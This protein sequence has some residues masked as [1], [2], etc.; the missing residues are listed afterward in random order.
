MDKQKGLVEVSAERAWKFLSSVKLA[1]VLLIILAIVSIVGTVIEQNQPTEKYLMEYSRG[2]VAVLD[3]FGFFDMYQTWWFVVLLFL[4]T[5]NLTV[6]TLDRFPK[7]WTIIRAPLRPIEDTALKAVPF[8]KEIAIQGGIDEAKKRSAEVLHSRKYRYL[9]LSTAEMTQFYMQ[10]G[11]YSRLGVYI[12]HVS[13][14]LIFMGALI[15]GVFGFKGFLRLDEGTQSNVVS[16]RNA[17][18]WDAIMSA[19]GVRESRVTINPA[20]GEKTLPLGFYLRCLDFEVDYY[21]DPR[22]SRP[23]GMAQEYY[24]ILRVLDESGRRTLIDQLRIEVNDPLTYRGITFYQS[25]YG[26]VSGTRGVIL[27]NVMQKTGRSRKETILIEP[28]SETYVPSIDRRIKVV[29]VALFGERD[30][31]TGQ[32]IYYRPRNNEFINPTVELEV[33]KGR[34]GKIPLYRTQVM[35]V[36]IMAPYM[37]E[38]YTIEYHDYWGVRYTGLQVTKDPGVWVVYVGF[39]LLCF[40]PLIAFFGS[41]RKLWVRITDNKGRALVTVAGSSNRNRLGFERE[42]NRI[43]DEI[44]R[45]DERRK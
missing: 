32:V 3:F 2:T 38:E 28:G 40:G 11:V 6:C 26:V 33:Y 17:P 43:V 45:Q 20:T 29:G 7:T 27:L 39:I 10:K 37:P 25:S 15:G 22:T 4:L 12:T 14:I 41:H 36:D 35:K 34:K 16:V 44:S 8:K 24:S 42:F 13:V 19:F 18:K 31:S 21:Q 5:A 30:P 23:M 9:E 1:V